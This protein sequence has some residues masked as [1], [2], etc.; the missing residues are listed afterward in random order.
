M[1]LPNYTCV[2]ID[3]AVIA[4]TAKRK[5]YTEVSEEFGVPRTVI[6]NRIKGQK[7]HI[8]KQSKG[9]STLSLEV[10]NIIENSLI[11]RAEMDRVSM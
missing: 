10:E 5:T 11:A 6:F 1:L 3:K 9:R 2:E 7:T 4:V 8:H